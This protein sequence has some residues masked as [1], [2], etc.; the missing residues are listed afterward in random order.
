[1]SKTF[2]LHYHHF[3]KCNSCGRSTGRLADF[4][5]C[6]TQEF[7]CKFCFEWTYNREPLD[8][9]VFYLKT[10]TK[11]WDDYKKLKA[12]LANQVWDGIRE[13]WEETHGKAED[14]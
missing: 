12:A 7:W 5:E 4:Y 8:H 9:N 10:S 6:S 13:I 14:I 1:M 3:P 11:Q 2:Y